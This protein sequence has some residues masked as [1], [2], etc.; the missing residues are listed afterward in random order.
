MV[1]KKQTIL[2]IEDDEAIREMYEL[3]FAHAGVAITTAID[4]K[5]ALTLAHKIKP[6]ILLLDIKIPTI[7]G[8]EVLED[9]QKKPWGKRMK[10]I[11]LSN[12][13]EKEAPAKLRELHYDR[14]MVKAHFTP[15]KVLRAVQDILEDTK[16]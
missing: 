7:G 12:I 16:H 15:T 4:G 11:I 1:P 9:L 5:Q 6:D 13:N 2:L 3:K 10:V 14:Y 8:E